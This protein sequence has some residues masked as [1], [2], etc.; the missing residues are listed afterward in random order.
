[1]SPSIENTTSN[2]NGTVST[3]TTATTTST[4]TTTSN[5]IPGSDDWFGDQV[6]DWNEIY[7]AVSK[8]RFQ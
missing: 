8:L 1:M 7:N 2:I 3:T 6:H 5:V 4:T